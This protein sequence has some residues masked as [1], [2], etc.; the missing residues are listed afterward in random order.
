MLRYAEMSFCLLTHVAMERCDTLEMDRRS[1]VCTGVRNDAE[2][3]AVATRN[4]VLTNVLI[5]CLFIEES[6][7]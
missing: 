6:S 1:S 7:Y 4:E 3:W 5:K 2:T